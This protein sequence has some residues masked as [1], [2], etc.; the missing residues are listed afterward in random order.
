MLAEPATPD[1]TL[2]CDPD[3]LNVGPGGRIPLFVQLARRAGFNG[4]VKI[5]L[6]PLPA[7]VAVSPLTVGPKMT[8]GLLV[9]SAALEAKPGATLLDLT[10]KADAASGTV[11]RHVGPNQEIYMPGGGRGRFPVNTLA[12]GVTEPDDIQVEASPTSITLKPGGTATIDVTVTRKAGFEGGVNLA[13]IYQHLG[14]SHGNPLPPGVTIREAGGKTLLG[15]KETKGKLVLQAAP[16]A[17]AIEAVPVCVMGHVS[18]NFVV[19]TSYASAPIALSI[20][21]K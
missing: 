16:N 6:G 14:Y 4:P 21:T 19:K 11:V 20:A 18:I 17:E 13:M 8:E 5:D 12:L 15:P 1:F 7:G 3:K 2:T 9:V 10:G